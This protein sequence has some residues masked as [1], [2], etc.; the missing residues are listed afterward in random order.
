MQRIKFHFI[1]EG[2]RRTK[3]AKQI[4]KDGLKY[5]KH[6]GDK[7]DKIIIFNLAPVLSNCTNAG[8]TL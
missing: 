3:L 6:K 1:C 8:F 4:L 2:P 5:M 7:V